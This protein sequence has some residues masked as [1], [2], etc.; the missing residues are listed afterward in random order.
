MSI[1]RIKDKNERKSN[2]V[3]LRLNEET[4]RGVQNDDLKQGK[5]QLSRNELSEL[6][7]RNQNRHKENHVPADE[8]LK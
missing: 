2:D 4:K 3:K 5:E 8:D 7:K 6:L 1:V